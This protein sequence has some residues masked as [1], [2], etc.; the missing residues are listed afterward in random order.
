ME[1]NVC[2]WWFRQRSWHL[3]VYSPVRHHKGHTCH[4]KQVPICRPR[5]KILFSRPITQSQK[6]EHTQEWP[7]TQTTELVRL[8]DVVETFISRPRR[9]EIFK[10]RDRG[11]TFGLRDWGKARHFKNLTRDCFEVNQS[12]GLLNT[13][14]HYITIIMII[15]WEYWVLAC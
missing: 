10:F 8:S 9:G 1:N 3:Y 7:S 12:R 5:M 6:S 14:L 11:K 4:M 13:L 15:N 2:R